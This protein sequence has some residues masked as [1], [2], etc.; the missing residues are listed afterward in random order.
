MLKIIYI[1]NFLSEIKCLKSLNKFRHLA[2]TVFCVNTAWTSSGFHN[3]LHLPGCPG[4]SP[5]MISQPIFCIKSC[6]S[7]LLSKILMREQSL[8][9]SIP[10]V[11]KLQLSS[12]LPT[13]SESFPLKNMQYQGI[14]PFLCDPVYRNLI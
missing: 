7:I 4:N 6:I 5:R 13:E 10:I 11:E 8:R 2:L 14:D 9:T 12:I 3:L 1:S